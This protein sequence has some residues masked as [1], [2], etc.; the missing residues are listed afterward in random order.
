MINTFLHAIRIN[1]EIFKFINVLLKEIKLSVKC[2]ITNLYHKFLS[3][4]AL[5]K[6]SFQKLNFRSYN[7]L[8]FEDLILDFTMQNKFF[9]LAKKSNF[10]LLPVKFE[11]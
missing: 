7:I 11:T 8:N 5:S 3:G 4:K 10:L 9:M 6:D 1:R 2:A